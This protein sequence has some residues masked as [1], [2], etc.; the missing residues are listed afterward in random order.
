MKRYEVTYITGSSWATKRRIVKA[1]SRHEA[2]LKFE[3]IMENL[4]TN[5]AD[6]E[7]FSVEEA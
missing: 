4:N 3:R 5:M 6:L 7:V 2:W 1:E